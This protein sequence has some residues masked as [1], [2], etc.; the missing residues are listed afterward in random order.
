MYKVT[1]EAS[2]NALDIKKQLEK[3]QWC[4]FDRAFTSKRKEQ[5]R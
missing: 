4:N 2:R 5:T 1:K 3:I